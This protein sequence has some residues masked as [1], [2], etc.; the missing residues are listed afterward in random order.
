MGALTNIYIAVRV[1]HV[2]FMLFVYLYPKWGHVDTQ[3]EHSF[4][5]NIGFSFTSQYKSILCLRISHL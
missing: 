5:W 4:W 1:G 3:R 2:N